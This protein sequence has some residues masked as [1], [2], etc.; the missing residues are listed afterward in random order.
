MSVDE[1]LVFK[2]KQIYMYSVFCKI[3]LTDEGKSSVEENQLH[4]DAHRIHSKIIIDAA[5]STKVDVESSSF[6]TYITTAKFGDDSWK[7]SSQSFII[8]WK[9]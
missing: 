3:T 8:H 7:G 9:D 6:L 2:E 4:S 1:K 5:L